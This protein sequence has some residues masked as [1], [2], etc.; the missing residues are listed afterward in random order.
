MV[1]VRVLVLCVHMFLI[2]FDCHLPHLTERSSYLRD[3]ATQ[4][5]C[6]F[7]NL[8]RYI[9]SVEAMH[10]FCML[11]TQQKARTIVQQIE[12]ERILKTANSHTVSNRNISQISSVFVYSL[13][14]H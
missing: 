10:T 5:S 11:Q 9:G 6:C 12:N 3:R 8:E 7:S 1:C 14:L 13:L 2:V 4:Y